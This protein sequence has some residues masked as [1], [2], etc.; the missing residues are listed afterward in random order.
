MIASHYYRLLGSN[1]RIR[2]LQVFDALRQCLHPPLL[3]REGVLWSAEAARTAR[4]WTKAVLV[5]EAPDAGEDKSTSRYDD[6]N[7]NDDGHE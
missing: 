1:Q 3:R 2:G 7:G 5:E 4:G 6:R